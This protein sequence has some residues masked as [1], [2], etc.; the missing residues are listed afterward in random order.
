M[1]VGL[2]AHIEGPASLVKAKAILSVRCNPAGDHLLHI[3][4]SF[5]LYAVPYLRV[6]ARH[7]MYTM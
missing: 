5:A 7:S 2:L 3:N 4:A 6:Y 1:C